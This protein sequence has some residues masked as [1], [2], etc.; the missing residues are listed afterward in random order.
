MKKKNLNK[1]KSQKAT[2]WF[3]TAVGVHQDTFYHEVKIENYSQLSNDG[4][5]E[6]LFDGIEQKI[7]SL[8]QQSDVVVGASSWLTN[9]KILKALTKLHSVA[10]IIRKDNYPAQDPMRV[11]NKKLKSFSEFRVTEDYYR[12]YDVDG[13]EV[14]REPQGIEGMIFADEWG[15]TRLLHRNDALRCFGYHSEE[16]KTTPLMHHKFLIFGTTL[17]GYL[18]EPTLVMTG[19]FNL[20]NNASNSRENIVLLRQPEICLA[21]LKE[22]AQLWQFSQ[23]LDWNDEEPDNKEKDPPSIIDSLKS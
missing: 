16:E 5:V 23:P 14:A 18:I 13:N 4:N 17:G 11:Y 7:I 9:S 8:I 3:E 19:S 21:Y 10:I 20:S 12:D 6:V 15:Q 22:W 2:H 1:V